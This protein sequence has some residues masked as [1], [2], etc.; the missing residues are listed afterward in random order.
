M[1]LNH[2]LRTARLLAGLTQLALAERIGS[3]EIEV[4]RFETGRAQPATETKQ[5]IA[6]VLKKQTFELF[7]V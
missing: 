7:D 2:R 1:A 5:R 6:Q 3:K 4:S